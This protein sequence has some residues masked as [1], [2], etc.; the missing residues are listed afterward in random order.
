MELIENLLEVTQTVVGIYTPTFEAMGNAFCPNGTCLNAT[1]ST[2]QRTVQNVTM[3][4][5]SLLNDTM[6]TGL[7]NT[8]LNETQTVLDTF[9]AGINLTETFSSQN[10]E[11]ALDSFEEFLAENEEKSAFAGIFGAF[12][13]GLEN[14]GLIRKGGRN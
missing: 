13:Q 10:V 1:A 4:V 7:F 5:S 8:T 11:N 6:S 2:V 14:S 3:A 9:G 12:R